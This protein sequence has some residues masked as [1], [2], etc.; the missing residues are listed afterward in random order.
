MLRQN[1]TQKQQLKINP[2]Q[3]Q[4]LELFHL[5]S[6]QLEQRIKN[7]LE[8]NPII[9][10]KE[11]SEEIETTNSKE[12]VQEFQDWDEYGYDDIPDYKTENKQYYQQEDMPDK[13]I[14]AGRDFKVDL[15]EQLSAVKLSEMH[16]S[17]AQFIIGNLN[18]KGFL[19]TP[20][21][22]LAEDF[23]L[24]TMQWIEGEEAEKILHVIQQ[25]EP[26]G[27]GA[28]E[29]RECMMLQLKRMNT[30]RPDV[31]AA[32]IIL[33]RYYED[34]KA[35]NFEKIEN[36]LQID[37]EELRMVLEMMG[38]LNLN[39]IGS[40]EEKSTADT[41]IPDFVIT[42]R[43]DGM[44]VRLANQRSANLVISNRMK[45]MVK[46]AEKGK[47]TR[48][49]QYLKSKLNSA[50]WFVNA[51]RQRETTMLNVINAIVQYQFDYF[52]DGDK[53]QL[54]PMILKNIAEMAGV[55]ISTVSRITCN[56]YVQTPF[57]TIL[58]KSLFSE[59]IENKSG[60][61]ISNKVI[62]KEIEEVIK[63]ED[64]KSPYSD[65]QLASLLATRGFNIARRTVTK[66]REHLQIPVAQM[67][68]FWA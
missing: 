13:P 63:C 20:L 66:Y 44:E 67:R 21:E 17:F 48:T 11:N 40:T 39:P 29:I 26:A 25:C 46:E 57:G 42:H 34:L 24:K 45:A 64:K 52:Q 30:K 4:M 32:I 35:R 6:L 7:E 15:A 3:L 38:T 55:D 2:Q 18:E 54:R 14:V 65:Q 50:E 23:S 16:D 62:Q 43:D 36:A 9:E 47:D 10:E 60:A 28:R 5:T 27:V 61:I 12:E 56:K 49:F 68:A 58:L 53:S 41:I 31:K 37:E 51:I 1:L 33:E 59:G 22:T 8:E 19:E